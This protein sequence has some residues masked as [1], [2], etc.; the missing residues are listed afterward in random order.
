M[1]KLTKVYDRE[2]NEYD[3]TPDL[4]DYVTNTA[5][6]SY[7]TDYVAQVGHTGRAIHLVQ[8]AGDE[9]ILQCNW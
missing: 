3:L 9:I 2:G 6:A 7:V 8:E 1:E 4:S 5:M